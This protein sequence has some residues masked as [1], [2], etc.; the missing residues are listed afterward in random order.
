MGSAGIP[1]SQ[2]TSDSGLRRLET[3]GR[4][5]GAETTLVNRSQIPGHDFGMRPDKEVWQRHGGSAFA[6]IFRASLPTS[7]L[8]PVS[9][10]D[11]RD[12]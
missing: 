2:E 8:R 10:M 4:E 9:R 7:S 1:V 12:P 3:D 6:R 11:H 5:V